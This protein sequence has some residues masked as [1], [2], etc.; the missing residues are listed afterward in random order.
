VTIVVSDTSPIR[1]LA[2]LG[3]LDL[4]QRLYGEVIIPRAV[5]LELARAPTGPFPIALD[6]LSEFSFVKVE[7]VQESPDLGRFRLEL[8][9]G[10]SEALAL[11]LQLRADLILMDEVAGRSVA[12]REGLEVIGVL[13]VLLEAKHRGH[14]EAIAP[15][16]DELQDRHQ[17]FIG[18]QLRRQI[19]RAAGE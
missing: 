9:P 13:G 5:A 4:L 10:E 7:T 17:F 2:N 18:D 1:A 19:L 8:D 16:V 3:L 15:M 14:I 12:R 6:D 11:A